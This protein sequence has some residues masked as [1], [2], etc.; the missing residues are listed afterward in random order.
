MN[1][2]K[3][4]SSKSEK[5]ATGSDAGSVSEGIASPKPGGTSSKM[6]S[7]TRSVDHQQEGV[8]VAANPAYQL[9]NGDDMYEYKD[10]DY[11]LRIHIVEC[12]ELLPISGSCIVDPVVFIDVCGRKVH[13]KQKKQCNSC[14]FDEYFYI[15][16]D[17]MN[18]SKIEDGTIA[19]S[20]LDCS[21]RLTSM[22]SK[23][24]IGAF[25]TDLE[26]V[27]QSPA[28]ELYRQW[29][30][31]F[32]A[33]R[34]GLTGKMMLTLELLGPGDKPQVHDRKAEILLEKKQ[35]KKEGAVISP[36]L[37]AMPQFAQRQCFLV[38]EIFKAEG[39]PVLD[40][41]MFTGKVYSHIS[42]YV[43]V[44]FDRHEKVHTESAKLSRGSLNDADYM[45]ALWLP[46]MDPC[47]SNRIQ[48]RV[49]E[50]HSISS[51]DVLASA[52]S[53][54]LH[55]RLVKQGMEGKLHT[56]GGSST[57][58][59][60]LFW[61][62]LYGAPVPEVAMGGEARKD[63]MNM[64]PD[65]ASAYRGRLLVR[66]RIDDNKPSKKGKK[67]GPEVLK[68]SITEEYLRASHSD[69]DMSSLGSWFS[70]S[71]ASTKGDFNE[72]HKASSG[73]GI[74][75]SS[76]PPLPVL[77]SA[78]GCADAV[79]LKA[80][81]NPVLKL[82]SDLLGLPMP[83]TSR[84]V[85]KA[86]VY[87][88][89][90]F[91]QGA[92][93]KSKRFS[94]EL[95]LMHRRLLTP[96]A[97]MEDN[98]IMW[99]EPVLLK[100]VFDLPDD[101]AM[102][103]DLFMYILNKEL[104]PLCYKRFPLVDFLN[105]EESEQFS[106]KPDWV[107]PKIDKTISS[108]PHD[109]FPG[110][111]LM[112][113]GL[114]KEAVANKSVWKANIS[115]QCTTCQ[116]NLHV[117]QGRGLPPSDSTGLL[118]PYVLVR[119]GTSIIKT[120]VHKK[121]RD[122]QFME[123][124]SFHM[125]LPVD[126]NLK[127]QLFLE[128]FDEDLSGDDFVGLVKLDLAL[129]DKRAIPE[130]NAALRAKLRD[131]EWFSLRSKIGADLMGQLLVGYEVISLES[132]AQAASYFTNEQ[133]LIPSPSLAPECLPWKLEMT[134]LGLRD[135][136]PAGM[137]PVCKPYV[138]IG[139]N[140]I[141]LRKLPPSKKPT[142]TD[143][144]YLCRFQERVMLPER[145]LYAPCINIGAKDRKLGVM[146]STIIG[147]VSIPLDDKMVLPS[148][149]TCAGKRQSSSFRSGNP[150][151]SQEVLINSQI[152]ANDSTQSRA[153]DA[154]RW[155]DGLEAGDRHANYPEELLASALQATRAVNKN[156]L[157]DYLVDRLMLDCELES[158]L[159]APPFERYALT[160]GSVASGAENAFDTSFCQVSIRI[161]LTWF[162]IVESTRLHPAH[163][164]IEIVCSM[165]RRWAC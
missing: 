45:T 13:T 110:A 130:K 160:T 48:L 86:M 142:P 61:V 88:G 79:T 150:Y 40:K 63:D 37:S 157:A 95:R 58:P 6:V 11:Q 154:C 96:V 140:G 121:T 71:P 125:K 113:I 128:I 53:P 149:N 148:S 47:F 97:R 39:I 9:D 59:T 76:A 18:R 144:N 1:F 66:L 23:N 54:A 127:P 139:L 22:M 50:H 7:D 2:L 56:E 103:P 92:F 4:K 102:M 38:V 145:V 147:S 104:E 62:N 123:T 8:G 143:P 20:V 126:D 132:A 67:K 91:P 31:L 137:I 57:D 89:Q 155:E 64:Y 115:T 81:M 118:D 27:Y 82:P 87:A 73:Q 114:G 158:A 35:R 43:N 120:K 16:L 159:S 69:T 65:T 101:P 12:L 124:L 161:V 19:I 51:D 75:V 41:S 107:I 111:V 163:E 17:N 165:N 131:P 77:H 129:A 14:I 93:L 28:H 138:T 83:K 68:V 112:K 117:Y 24:V 15:Q 146:T 106:A 84:Y 74:H 151:I 85:L 55:L 109:I 46:Y 152:R 72:S 116:V 156:D 133:K 44:E 33:S 34:A 100:E 94:V 52:V 80:G 49:V 5:S 134:V 141:E 162:G 26:T 135:L 99:P 60:Q 105:K 25:N 136:E 29:I 153:E 122:P 98:Y 164:I 32:S 78:G 36:S 30:P 21:S 90:S 108:T 3:K 42:A 119:V 10:G 70:V